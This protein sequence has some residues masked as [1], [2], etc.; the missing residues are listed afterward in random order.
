MNIDKNCFFFKLKKYK[1]KI[2]CLGK[3]KSICNN[4]LVYSNHGNEG[5]SI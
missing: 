2:Q 3:N 4:K 5:L 1:E